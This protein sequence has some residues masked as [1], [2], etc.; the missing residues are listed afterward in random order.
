MKLDDVQHLVPE[1]GR[2][3]IR[4]I[5]LRNTVKLVNELGGT[6]FPVSLGKNRQGHIR[7][8][9]LAEVVGVEAAN[10]LT[11]HFGGDTLYIP[12][13]KVALRELLQREIRSE[14]DRIT[15]DHSALHAVA[16]LAARYKMSDRHIWRVLKRENDVGMTSATQGALF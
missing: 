3:L 6:S 13:C 1:T 16:T 8:E 9:M 10:V 2:L 5:G 11:R 14:F 7:Y 4:L 15:R 12:L